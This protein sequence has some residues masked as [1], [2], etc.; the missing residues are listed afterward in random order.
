M[1]GIRIVD[2]CFCRSNNLRGDR[3]RRSLEMVDRLLSWNLQNR[4]YRRG[5]GETC[6]DT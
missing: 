4:D 5:H 2:V 1:V 6:L 3:S